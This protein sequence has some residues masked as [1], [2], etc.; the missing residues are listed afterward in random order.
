[1]RK[2]IGSSPV[3]SGSGICFFPDTSPPR[4]STPPTSP[5]LISSPIVKSSCPTLNPNNAVHRPTLDKGI[6]IIEDKQGYHNKRGY[7]QY[8][9]FPGEPEVHSGEVPSSPT[10][11]RKTL[12]TSL[13]SPACSSEI[14]NYFTERMLELSW[15]TRR[16]IAAKV[17]YQRLHS[18]E[19]ELIKS[20]NDD[21]LKITRK[22]LTATDLQ[23]GSL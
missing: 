18:I 14:S 17:R 9:L 23:I 8:D 19:L 4:S 11:K 16:V 6:S 13:N 5:V 12:K 2:A 1:M 20:I 3:S 10:K 7:M 21:E 22:E 15:V